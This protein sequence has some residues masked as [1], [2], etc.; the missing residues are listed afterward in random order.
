[1]SEN[2]DYANVTSLLNYYLEIFDWN[3]W[4]NKY[5]ISA[6]YVIKECKFMNFNVFER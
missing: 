5:G 4:L 6:L 1:M 3:E 2:H